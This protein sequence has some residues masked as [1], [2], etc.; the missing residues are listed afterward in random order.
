MNYTGAEQWGKK[1]ALTAKN[2][3]SNAQLMMATL[4]A[5]LNHFWKFLKMPMP[6]FRARPAKS[7][8]LIQEVGD[9]Y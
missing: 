2:L 9:I 1:M 7:E 3:Y 8:F 5:Y 4:T 6:E